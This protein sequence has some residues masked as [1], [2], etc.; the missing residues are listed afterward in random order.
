VFQL[1]RKS[2]AVL[3]L[4]ILAVVAAVAAMQYVQQ[5]ALPETIASG[6]GRLEATEVD[7]ATKFAGRLSRVNAREGDDVEAGQILASVDASELEAE[8]WQ[9]QAL[10]TQAQTQRSAAVAVIA[11]RRSELTL[12]ERNLVRYRTLY[13]KRDVSTELLQRNETIVQT[14]RAALAAAEA[15]LNH[16]E[17]VIEAA[18]AR[19]DAIRTRIDDSELKTPISGRVLYQLAQP[20]E[21]LGAGGKVLTVLDLTDVYMTIFLPTRQAG[22]LRVGDEARIVLDALPDYVV[23]ATVSFVSPKAQFT[24]KEVETRTEREK[25]M[26][27]V[28]VRIS[29]ALL[30][31]HADIRKTGVPGVAFVRVDPQAEW[32]ER[33]SERLPL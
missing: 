19:V 2:V 1:G 13:E 28:K 29:P 23:P 6:N 18:V 4:A 3:A 12:A 31:E 14:A 8:L 9:A 20:G 11:H 26:F 33:L 16:A 22:R 5:P 10:V 27:R 25:L 7:I 30:A 21:V 15:E 17:A 32:P 24:P